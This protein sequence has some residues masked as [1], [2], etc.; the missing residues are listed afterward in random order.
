M[1]LN[2]VI[3]QVNKFISDVIMV[4]FLAAGSDVPI[5]KEVALEGSID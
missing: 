2:R 4:E 5:F 1:L 3:R